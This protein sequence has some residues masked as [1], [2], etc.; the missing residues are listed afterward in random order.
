VRRLNRLL[1][2][3]AHRDLAQSALKRVGLY[4]AG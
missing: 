1:D 4:H 2:K 3:P